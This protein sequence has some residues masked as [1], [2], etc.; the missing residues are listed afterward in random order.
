MTSLLIFL[1][2]LMTGKVQPTLFNLDSAT[3]KMKK[4]GRF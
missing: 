2:L 3:S 1:I 4:T